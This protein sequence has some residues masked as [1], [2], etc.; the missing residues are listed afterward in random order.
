MFKVQST[1]TGYF[2]WTA[3][4]WHLFEI[5]FQVFN[6]GKTHTT[7]N[8]SSELFTLSGMKDTHTGVRPL[9]YFKHRNLYD[10]PVIPCPNAYSL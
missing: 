7:R 3:Y 9:V 2:N 5:T 8:L 1:M 10:G 4:R 6:C